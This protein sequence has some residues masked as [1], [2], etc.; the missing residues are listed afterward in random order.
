[1]EL[2]QQVRLID[3][4]QGIDRLS[5][6]LIIEGKI[7]AIAASI[8]EYPAQTRIISGE[9]KILGTGLV[10]LYSYSQEPGHESRES[11]LNLAQAAAA[12]G[13]TQV[14]I[15][16]N[17]TPQI[18]S[19]EILAGMQ[20]KSDSIARQLFTQL[21]FW[22]AASKENTTKQM[23]ELA[24]LKSGVIGFSDRY[25][26]GNLNLLK[27]LL[28]YVQPWNKTIAIALDRNE[29]AGNGVVREGDAS[30]RYG[31][32]GNPGFSEAAIIAAVLEIVADIPTPVHLMRVSTQRSVELIADAKQR[33]IPV[34]ASTTW[35]HLLWDSE[36]VGSYDPNLRLE[37]PLGN[38]SDRTAL[39]AGIKQG[40]IDAIAIDHRAYTYEEK[41]VPFGLAPPGAIGLEIALPLLWQELVEKDR[42][43]AL[44]LWQ[45]LSTNP[46]LCLQQQPIEISPEQNS[47]LILF[48]PHKTWVG[49]PENLKSPAANTPYYNQK[50]SGKVMRIITNN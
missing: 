1:M 48:D 31:M 42:L 44:E 6:V 41:T 35:M 49:N 47:N 45:A 11:L 36:A 34:T 21:K 38:K 23:N 12:G 46:L 43:S 16:P 25:S 17:T 18:E 28:E 14:G 7:K 15:L 3:P 5:D 26:F 40:I 19:V 2:L 9:G 50:I 32:S 8:A 13:F 4:T 10:D 27:Q 37:P 30:I 33:N 24:E 39:I 29:L 20:Q 22:G